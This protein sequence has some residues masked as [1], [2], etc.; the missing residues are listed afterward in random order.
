MQKEVVVLGGNGFLGSNLCE[1]FWKKGIKPIVLDKSLGCD[2][3]TDVGQNIFNDVLLNLC[4]IDDIDVVMMAARLGAEL[5]ENDPIPLYL[6]NK[7]INEKCIETILN[8]SNPTS[9]FHI[10]FYS[11]S[12]VYGN[13]DPTNVPETLL[14]TIDPLYGRSLYAQEKL[15]TETVLNC[16]RDAKKIASLRV[17]RPFN[18]S[19]K[20]Q[21]RGV[22]HGMVKSA[23]CY[24]KIKYVSGQT[25]EITFVQDAT[26]MA[27]DAILSREEGIFDLTSQN[28]ISLKDLAWSIK[29]VLAMSH[30]LK[31][32]SVTVEEDPPIDS[33]IKTRGT[34]NVISSVGGI[35]AFVK[36]LAESNAIENILSTTI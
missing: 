4:N 2:L 17:F 12:E 29:D 10:S 18:V 28:H 3:A 1:A 27:L 11:T 30:P 5:F 13:V 7:A 33:Y 9:K 23:V 19:G 16:L 35:K 8:F 26:K 34:V 24:N 31:Y 22:V 36:R 25:R 15:A 20:W 14:P 21:R 6:E 32:A